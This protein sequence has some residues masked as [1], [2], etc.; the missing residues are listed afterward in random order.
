M[1]RLGV[2][3][4]LRHTPI[5]TPV[6]FVSPEIRVQFIAKIRSLEPDYFGHL[7]DF[8]PCPKCFITFGP[9]T[10]VFRREAQFSPL[11]NITYFFVMSINKLLSDSVEPLSETF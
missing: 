11:K 8:T 9:N 4:W 5:D 2:K 7:R 1:V 6:R 10:P 3:N